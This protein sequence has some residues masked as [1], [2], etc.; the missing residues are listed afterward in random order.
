MK[1]ASLYLVFV[2]TILAIGSCNNDHTNT[3]YLSKCD[4]AQ[5]YMAKCLGYSPHLKQCDPEIADRILDTPCDNLE[6]LWR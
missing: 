5:V 3:E 2:T 4:Q 1:K 6:N